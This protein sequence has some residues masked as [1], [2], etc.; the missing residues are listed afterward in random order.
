MELDEIIGVATS[1]LFF[2]FLATQLSLKVAA[3]DPAGH[4]EADRGREL[5]DFLGRVLSS[6]DVKDVPRLGP[7]EGR[8]DALGQAEAAGVVVDG[9][10]EVGQVPQD[11]P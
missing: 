2:Q 4:G 10:L 9:R 11:E 5:P 7:P 6:K 1:A 8:R 3:A